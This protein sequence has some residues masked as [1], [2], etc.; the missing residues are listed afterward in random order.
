[1]GCMEQYDE[2]FEVCPFCG[3]VDGT[4]DEDALHITP[5]EILHER[6]IVGKVIGFG[7]FGVTYIGWDALLEH[8]IAVK[9]YMPSEFSTRAMGTKE[10]T[11]FGGK[12]TEQFN[13]GL[14]KF[15][16][17]AHKIAKFNTDDGIVR[18]YDTSEENNTAYIIM[19]LLEGQTLASYLQQEGKI[20]YEKAVSIILP[21]AQALKD[22]HAAGVIHRDIAPDN[23][24]LTK[25]GK[26]KLIDFGAARFA[27]TSHSRSLS[28]L[29]KQGYSPEEQY[30]SR[31]DQG[32][33]TDVYALGA[34]LYR[35]ITGETP[36]DAL[37][38]RAFLENKKKDI[39]LP[40][41]NF[42]KD[43]PENIQAAI[44]NATNVRIE[45]RTQSADELIEELTTDQPVKRKKGKIK[46]IDFLRWPLW[47]KITFPSLAVLVITLSVL[48]AT[49]VIGFK[50]FIKEKIYVPEGMA[51]VPSIVSSNIESADDRLEKANLLY[52][53]SGKEYSSL[54]DA[55]LILSQSVSGGSVVLQNTII[56]LIISGGAETAAVPNI[57]GMPQDSAA[58]L[59]E[60]SGFLYKIEYE[61]SEAIA[62]GGIIR[63]S[64][65]PDSDYPVGNEITITVSKGRDP[66][67]E[68]EE[69]MV[70]VPDF[71]GLTYDEA[72]KLAQ[73]H[74]LI[75][76]AKEKAY[77]AE[78]AKDTVMGQSVTAGSE[79]LSGN[80]VELTVSL[81]IHIIKIPDVVY[82]TEQD[83]VKILEGNELKASITYENSETIKAGLVISQ[84]PG[85]GAEASAGDTVTLVVSKGGTAFNMPNVVGMDE[86]SARTL[87]TGKGLSVTVAYEY[88]T[89]TAAGNVLKQSISANSSVNL[90]TAVQ[91]T[92]SSGEE[93]LQVANVVGMAQK[94]AANA[95]KNQGFTV[96]V[97]E[98]YSETV[99]SGKVISQ[100]PEAGS[101]QIKNTIVL[102][103]VSKG[104]A[105]IEVPDV[106]GVSQSNA[107]STMKA[108]KLN[109]SITKEYSET[110]SY[111]SVISQ[112]PPAGSKAYS[113]D[114]VKLVICKGRE[115]VTIPNVVGM[116]SDTAASKLADLGFVV[117]TTKQYSDSVA[118]GK[119]IS[120]SPESGTGY[121]ND[122][123]RIVVSKGKSPVAPSAITLDQSSVT[124]YVGRINS[125]AQLSATITP[126]NASD[127]TVSWTSSDEKIA[128]V[129]SNGFVSAVSAGTA[130]IT[131]VTN[132]GGK[133][134]V[135]TVKVVQPTLALDVSS[136]TVTA[137]ISYTIQCTYSPTSQNITWSSSDPNVAKVDNGKVTAVSP[138][139]AV[140]TAVSDYGVSASSQITVEESEIFSFDKTS[141]SI[142]EGEKVNIGLH[143]DAHGVLN[144]SKGETT[145]TPTVTMAS[146]SIAAFQLS[147][148]NGYIQ[149]IIPGEETLSF[150]C[151]GKTIPIRLTVRAKSV[152][153]IS[154]L[155][156]PTKVDYEKGDT[157]D[158]TGLVL[159]VK[160]DNG[161]SETVNSN[162]SCDP[163]ILDQVGTQVITV[164]YGGKQTTFTVNVKESSYAAG[165]CGDTCY[166][167][168]NKAS[169][170]L[171]I[172]G[173][174]QMQTSAYGYPWDDYKNLITSVII[175]EGVT[176]L[177]DYA[178]VDC[179]KITN[180]AFPDSLKGIPEGAFQNC[181][182][183]TAITLGPNI[184]YIRSEAFIFCP[185]L[186]NIT[187]QN[188]T[189]DISD[190]FIANSYKYYGTDVYVMD[191]VIY[192]YSNSTAQQFAD[193]C[194]DAFSTLD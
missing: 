30:R 12:K 155:S 7:G 143:V 90:G 10:V 75:I 128:A 18:V 35:M 21:I 177:G 65:A 138:G 103:T 63:Q 45:D 9:E 95:L 56:D 48:F 157:L 193:A 131:A 186:V 117:T 67:Q 130:T 52:S 32:A 114:T 61:F 81:G 164:E 184:E 74:Q 110:A 27:T 181:M 66:D 127:K 80:T 171:T 82:K 93:L 107:E 87:L 34:V 179:T 16:E 136:A 38:R 86:N 11:V 133:K 175:E 194:G 109:V 148:N 169:G 124:L 129:T 13:S 166:W 119:V 176:A 123:I 160:Y 113:G 17:E 29:I 44:Y 36:P 102:L 167:K 8:K 156:G 64:V 173:T 79:I 70:S 137:G 71:T 108:L 163:A 5:G 19:E 37:E 91:I 89:S 126:S 152:S 132:T 46:A 57:I 151:C 105:P 54:I 3:Y 153:E 168:L 165:N 40:I 92:V 187:I 139:E 161:T 118:S 154:V 59:L 185:Y 101:S 43:V 42:A 192:G 120:Q 158:T 159:D 55:D 162:I 85:N 121:K 41:T 77:S 20:P 172:S 104:K 150:S 72:L 6:Y 15:H 47:A 28:V 140:I 190:T 96:K 170:E 178:F 60:E 76:I 115:P 84:S 88:S 134:A 53:I 1:M 26:V 116:D 62:E 68:Y 149:G 174:G 106:T 25:D 122:T 142:V 24:F 33:Y 50:N 100:S 98:N 22:V 141:F 145:I 39:L 147:G 49:G 69:I 94:D 51:R 31:G 182:G 4:T 146:S 188:P 180:V 58:A 189:C 183:L 78:F 97:N 135:C 191:P 125:A 111:G 83:A 23:I 144:G 73:E 112:D 99:E 2:E 14:K